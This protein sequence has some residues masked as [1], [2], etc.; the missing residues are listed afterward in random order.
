[1]VD[2]REWVPFNSDAAKSRVSP[3]KTTRRISTIK[4]Q[5][6]DLFRLYSATE[7][8]GID[9]EC[10][11]GQPYYIEYAETTG[12]P[13]TTLMKEYHLVADISS[14]PVGSAFQVEARMTMWN[15]MEEADPWF[16]LVSFANTP[17]LRGL[18]L[19]PPD[20]P[21]KSREFV[22]YVGDSGKEVG[23]EGAYRQL[24]SPNHR[25]LYWEIKDATKGTSYEL[26]WSW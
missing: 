15:G 24:E 16:D 7:G 19:F 21:Y 14:V 8:L 10:L 12:R 13:R 2:M 9:V 4:N 3:V 23:I 20:R 17:L 22:K 6:V 11:S 18:F 25:K 1:M 5:A 26:Q